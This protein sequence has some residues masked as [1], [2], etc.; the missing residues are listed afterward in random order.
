MN[1]AVGTVVRGLGV[2]MSGVLYAGFGIAGPAG[3]S[4]S[5]AL[6]AFVMLTLVAR[7]PKLS[8]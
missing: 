8:S 4:I 7:K 2:S 1:T 6:F 3:L 5:T